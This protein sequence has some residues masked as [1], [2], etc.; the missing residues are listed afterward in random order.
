MHMISVR[1]IRLVT[2]RSLSRS[3]MEVCVK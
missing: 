1:F 3:E 2:D